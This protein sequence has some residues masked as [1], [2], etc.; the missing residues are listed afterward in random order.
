MGY[1][2]HFDYWLQ[3]QQNT[4]GRVERK[5]NKIYGILREAERSLDE[6]RQSLSPEAV[7]RVKKDFEKGLMLQWK[8]DGFE[9]ADVEVEESRSKSELAEV[10][11][12]RTLKIFFNIISS[13]EE[14]SSDGFEKAPDVTILNESILFPLIFE[15]V[16]RGEEA[17]Y[18]DDVPYSALEVVKRGREWVQFFREAIP[19]AM[20]TPEGWVYQGL[21][22]E[23]WV[24][25]ALPLLYG[26][27]D[28]GWIDV[29]PYSHK[30]MMKWR[31]EPLSQALEAPLIHDAFELMKKHGEEIYETTKLREF[32]RATIETR[33]NTK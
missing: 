18:L 11:K 23:W 10:A 12:A 30:S 6:Y 22:Q 9:P 32:T 17:Y 20:S 8:R 24:N 5:Y 3:K 1:I 28:D 31:D 29:K 7:A 4:L 21:I 2:D 15:P 14:F 19:V 27:R 26:E 16:M 13:I 25:D 33:L